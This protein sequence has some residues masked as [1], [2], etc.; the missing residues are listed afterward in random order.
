M[1]DQAQEAPGIDEADGGVLAPT[2][3]QVVTGVLYAAPVVLTLAAHPAFAMSG[4]GGCGEDS[5]GD[6]GPGDQGND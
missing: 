3:R 4:S 6:C 2:R 1:S 5:Q